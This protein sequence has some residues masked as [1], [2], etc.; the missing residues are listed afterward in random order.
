MELLRSLLIWWQH[1]EGSDEVRANVLHI[2][3]GTDGKEIT[4]G[5]DLSPPLSDEAMQRYAET[6][7]K[8]TWDNDTVAAF[9]G[10]QLGVV[11]TRNPK[12]EPMAAAPDAQEDGEDAASA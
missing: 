10:A 7:G 12:P 11:V 5:Q 6:E 1:N 3:R 8:S 2:F 4:A 9:A